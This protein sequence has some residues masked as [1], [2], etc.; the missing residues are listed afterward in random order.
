[1]WFARLNQK[2]RDDT[3]RVGIL[4]DDSVD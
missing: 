2:M 3:V 4:T 1:V